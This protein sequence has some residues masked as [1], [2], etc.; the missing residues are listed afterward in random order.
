MSIT[1]QNLA[2]HFDLPGSAV[3]RLVKGVM[4]ATDLKDDEPL[5]FTGDQE[6]EIGRVLAVN[7]AKCKCGREFKPPRTTCDCDRKLGR[8]PHCGR[9]TSFHL[10]H[11]HLIAR[12]EFEC[13]R[14]G[15][16][17]KKCNY[18]KPSNCE[19]WAWKDGSDWR[20]FCPVCL[21]D[22][23]RLK[24]VRRSEDIARKIGTQL[25]EHIAKDLRGGR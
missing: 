22:P 2:E 24:D 25:G 6:L 10:L 9:F 15:S 4:S 16:A 7:S 5:L 19:R 11:S 14:C 23:E 13:D 1:I 8:C 3:A 12:D 17:V 20:E 21:N 18:A